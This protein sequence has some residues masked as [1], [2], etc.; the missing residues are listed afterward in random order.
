[1][2]AQMAAPVNID[3]ISRQV[4]SILN[5]MRSGLNSGSGIKMPAQTYSG[6]D[7]SRI[8]FPENALK[9]ESNKA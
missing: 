3:N 5:E 7:A 1:M 9:Q 4:D 6:S 8:T 2:E